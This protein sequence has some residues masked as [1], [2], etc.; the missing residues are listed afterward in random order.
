MLETLTSVTIIFG[1]KEGEEEI[2]IDIQ[3]SKGNTRMAKKLF[4][5]QYFGPIF[6]LVIKFHNFHLVLIFFNL[7]SF[8]SL[9]SFHEWKTPMGQT[10][11]KF[12]ILG[13]FCK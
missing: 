3:N 6:N 11:V 13:I 4:G 10:I 7:L 5:S 1:K 8:W 12:I 2:R 9:P